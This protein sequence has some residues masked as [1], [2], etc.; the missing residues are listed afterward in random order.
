MVAPTRVCE[1]ELR[2]CVEGFFRNAKHSFAIH[3]FDKM[4][5]T[6][7]LF[8]IHD[9]RSIH[10]S[11]LPRCARNDR[12]G[13]R[14][15]IWMAGDQWSPLREFARLNCGGVWKVFFSNAKHGFAIHAFDKT[16]FTKTL[17][18]IHDRRSIHSLRRKEL[19]FGWGEGRA[20]E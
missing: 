7:T 16:Q 6:K 3:A 20:V 8:S 2:G 11:R 5:F 13:A 17:F 14:G 1:V 12:D 4:Q 18:S 15:G 19:G 10:S 9:R